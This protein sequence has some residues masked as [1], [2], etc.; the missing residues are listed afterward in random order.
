MTY[1]NIFFSTQ[2]IKLFELSFQIW[3]LDSWTRL[4]S[5]LSLHQ[6][7]VTDIQF[8]K[9][10]LHMV[11]VGDKIAWWSLEHLPNRRPKTKRNSLADPFKRSRKISESKN[12]GNSPAS[13]CSPFSPT[14][15]E[16]EIIVK[17]GKFNIIFKREHRI[18]LLQ[19]YIFL[20]SPFVNFVQFFQFFSI[21]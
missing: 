4:Y 2:K 8:C 21:C 18:A 5:P 9:N 14:K 10:N 17:R 3:E 12:S 11:T 16:D 20:L 15:I 19:I 13:P 1:R 7:W 6:S